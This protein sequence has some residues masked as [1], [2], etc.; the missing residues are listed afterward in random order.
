MGAKKPSELTASS[1][2]TDAQ[3]ATGWSEAGLAALL[4]RLLGVYFTATAI[5]RATEQAVRIIIVSREIGLDPALS[6]YWTYLTDPVPE[7]L[8]GIYLLIGGRWVYEKLLTPIAR[9]PSKDRPDD[10]DG[11]SNASVKG[12]KSQPTNT[13]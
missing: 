6:E 2:T 4:M 11:P 7:L 5:M 8:F 1:R 3:S 13:E 9:N 12:D 10:L